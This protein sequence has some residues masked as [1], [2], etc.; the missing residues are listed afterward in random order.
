MSVADKNSGTKMDTIMDAAMERLMMLNTD[1]TFDM[2]E[3]QLAQLVAKGVELAKHYRIFADYDVIRFIDALAALGSALEQETIF[4]D[5][6]ND[7]ELSGTQ[8]LN[9]IEEY[10]LFQDEL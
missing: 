8:K 10:M 4:Q 5:I 9:R 7:P 6:L 3:E 1:K 2:D